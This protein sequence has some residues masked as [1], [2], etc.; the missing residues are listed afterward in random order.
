M[1][2][3]HSHYSTHLT[4]SILHNQNGKGIPKFSY[5]Q[6]EL[7]KHVVDG[8]TNQQIANEMYISINTVKKHLIHLFE[9]MDVTNRTSL[10]KK[11]FETGMV[12]LEE[13]HHSGL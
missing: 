11:V 13:R 10:V 2:I 6:L 5:R 4:A 9:M 3:Q 12:P 7:L 1:C 8:K